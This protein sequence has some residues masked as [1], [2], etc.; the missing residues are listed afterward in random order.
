[1]ADKAE[2]NSALQK[3]LAVLETVV[4]ELRPLGAVDIAEE[5][6]VPRQTAHR[7]IRQLEQLGLLQKDPS[8]ERYIPG[9]RLRTLAINTIS[10][11]QSTRGTH[12]ILDTLVSD[13][14]ETCNVGMLD[15]HEVIY[16]DRAE[17]D[18]PLRMQLRPGSHVPVHCTA[19][20]KLLLANLDDEQR[21]MILQTAELRKFTKYTTTS[22]DLLEAQLDQ[23]VAQGYAINNQEDAIGLVALAVPVHDPNGAVIAGLAVHAPEPR[24]SIAKAIDDLPKFKDAATRI[25]HAM[26]ALSSDK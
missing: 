10:S 26:F 17:C 15:G 2:T 13:I 11:T 25:G 22:P 12:A 24:Y 5:L 14:N 18:W 16:I 7:V 21:S 8:R 23:I 9:E 3:A 4:Q 19:I 1:M 6:K 20:G